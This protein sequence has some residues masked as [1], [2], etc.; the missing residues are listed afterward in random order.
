METQSR[1]EINQK[2]QDKVNSEK[3]RR[4]K[5]AADSADGTAAGAEETAHQVA[6]SGAV[7]SESKKTA[8]EGNA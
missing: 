4:E 3:A 7:E 5:A 6:S 1:E 8:G 2:I